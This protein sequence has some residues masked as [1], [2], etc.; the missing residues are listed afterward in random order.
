MFARFSNNWTLKLT[1]LVLSIALWSHVRGQVNPWENATFKVQL[2]TAPPRG[3]VLLNQKELP[4]TVTVT[5]RG[6]RLTLR[7]LKG[8]TP[9]N[10][11]ATV[12]D[13]PLLPPSV[14]RATLDYSAARKGEQTLPLKNDMELE[15]IE[16]LGAKPSEVTVVLDVAEERRFNVRPQF[17]V[18]D[19]W[20]IE[21]L[22]SSTQSATVFGPSQL[23]DR[24]VRVRARAP[25]GE[26]K[27]GTLKLS[28]VPLEAVD[29]DGDVLTSVPIEPSM[30]DLEVRLREKQVTKS[31]GITV[32]QI[33]RPASDY[34]IGEIDV[35]PP[36]LTVRGP[37]RLISSVENI[38]VIVDIDGASRTVIS[39][40]NVVLPTGVEAVDGS[41]VRARVEIKAVS[42]I[43]TPTP[44]LRTPNPLPPPATP[45][46]AEPVTPP[47]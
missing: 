36:R 4:K 31:V 7:S 6:P 25:R 33:G 28:N 11:L 35:V 12:D 38:P 16:V 23:L 46:V 22:K 30:V 9:A 37:R 47:A 19:D 43:P 41:R 45:A 39:R 2:V 20:E 27:A 44:T 18:G 24:V 1:A 5:L 15:D 10:P 8:P 40:K 14:L 3:F 42:P 13:A 32:E 17:F 26:L 21:Q 29:V 34:Q